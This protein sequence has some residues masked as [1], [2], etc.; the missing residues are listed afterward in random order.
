MCLAHFSDQ[1]GFS[2]I[3]PGIPFAA[4]WALMAAS[5]APDEAPPA[6][7]APAVR[8]PGS[9]GGQARSGLVAVDAAGAGAEVAAAVRVGGVA[10]VALDLPLRAVR[11]PDETAA[12]RPGALVGV[13]GAGAVVPGVELRVGERLA[14]LVA[15]HVAEGSQARAVSTRRAARIAPCVAV[16]VEEEGELDGYATD[17]AP[18]VPGAV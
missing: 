14:E 1:L 11:E 15:A 18:A 7:A 17:R 12:E 2:L 4:L 10:P 9:G 8:R 16:E 5:T 6:V 3:R 13:L